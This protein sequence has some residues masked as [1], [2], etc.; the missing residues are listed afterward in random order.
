MYTGQL[1]Y[2][3]SEQYEL[4]HTARKM[5]ISVLTKLLEAQMNENITQ[6]MKESLSDLMSENYTEKEKKVSPVDAVSE[7]R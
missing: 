4:Y 6:S 5:N 2:W 3:A 1:E 7:K